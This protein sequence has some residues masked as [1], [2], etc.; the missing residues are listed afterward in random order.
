VDVWPNFGSVIFRTVTRVF[1][2][3]CS[4]QE[5]KDLIWNLKQKPRRPYP[6]KRL[7]PVELDTAKLDAAEAAYRERLAI[8]REKK[9]IKI[10][11][12]ID[13][14][15]HSLIFIAWETE[16]VWI[17]RIKEY[18]GFITQGDSLE[19]VKKLLIEEFSDT[20]E[21]YVE[22]LEHFK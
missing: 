21:H 11:I 8:K 13:G 15:T 5:E 22:E 1:V 17:A 14:T 4:A 3:R 6:E 18:P 20:A 19:E 12:E 9:K 10:K 2:S 16:G 7:A